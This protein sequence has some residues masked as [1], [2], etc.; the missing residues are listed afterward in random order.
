MTD[1]ELGPNG[2]PKN[3]TELY[4][5]ELGATTAVLGEIDDEKRGDEDE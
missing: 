5:R 4:K 3:W 1:V 2:F